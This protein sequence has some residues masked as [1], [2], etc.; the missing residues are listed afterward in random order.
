MRPFANLGVHFVAILDSYSI[1]NTKNLR[2]I[3]PEVNVLLL[4]QFLSF[5]HC[6]ECQRAKEHLIRSTD[7]GG[8]KREMTKGH[9]IRSAD[10]GDEERAVIARN[11]KEQENTSSGVQM[12]VVN[13]E[14]EMTKEHL[15]RSA[16]DGGE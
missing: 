15:I 2:E 1:E 13:K 3:V 11:V 9:L 8:E 4:D 10:D 7:D 16:D 14:R 5:P 6:E 12:M